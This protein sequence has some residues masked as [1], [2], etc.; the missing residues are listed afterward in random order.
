MNRN[1]RRLLIAL[2]LELERQDWTDHDAIE[3]GILECDFEFDLMPSNDEN[4]VEWD[5][6][7]PDESDHA[8]YPLCV[9]CGN[10]SP[11]CVC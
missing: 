5:A 1:L 4:V 3:Y 9:E 11:S 2:Y 6:D 10:F 7:M 8:A